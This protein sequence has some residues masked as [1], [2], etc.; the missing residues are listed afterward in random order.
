VDAAKASFDEALRLNPRSHAAMT[1]EGIVLGRKG[2]L[3]EAEQTLKEALIQNPN[4]VRTHYELGLVYQK[5]GDL[6]KAI[7]EFEEGIKKH[8]QGRK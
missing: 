7:A 2:N 4:P 8:Q 6:E 1:G 3:K 5:S